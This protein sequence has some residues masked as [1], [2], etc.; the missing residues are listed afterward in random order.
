MPTGVSEIPEGT[1]S[2]F[3]KFGKRY[4]IASLHGTAMKFLLR[5]FMGARTLPA[6]T[7]MSTGKIN[8]VDLERIVVR[9]ADFNDADRFERPTLWRRLETRFGHQFPQQRSRLRVSN[10]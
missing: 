6:K 8:S 4:A 7:D 9:R 5:V 2:A 3:R 1:V 10:G